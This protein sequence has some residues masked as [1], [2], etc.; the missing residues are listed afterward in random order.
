MKRIIISVF[1]SICFISMGVLYAE[2]QAQEREYQM[3]ILGGST[4][5]DYKLI[6]FPV[7]PID[8]QDPLTNEAILIDDLGPYDPFQWRFFRWD[9]TLNGGLGDYIELNQR[10]GDVVWGNDQNIDYGRGYW[11]IA[12]Q[13]ETVNVSGIEDGSNK[14]I[15]LDEG[16]NQIGNPFYSLQSNLRVGPVGGPYVPLGDDLNVYTDKFVWE[17]V[18]GDYQLTTDPLE[19]GKGYWLKN[20]TEGVVELEFVPS[21]GLSSEVTSTSYDL[22]NLDVAQEEMPPSPPAIIEGS[23][24]SLSGGSAS[25]GCFIATAAYRDYDHPNV[26][27]L[28][29][30]R[31]RYLLTNSLG[32]IFVDMYYRWSPSVAKFIVNHDSMKA[33]IRFNLM[34]I[35]GLGSL[36]IKINVYG[37]LIVLVFPML[38]GLLLLIKSGGGG[39]KCK[40]KFSIKSEGGKGKR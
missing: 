2:S 9:S 4:A 19:V 15:I 40:P 5:A 28:R 6:S 37:F 25:G 3:T 33:L 27:R 13:T 38:M 7:K 14:T 1:I 16:W 17:W 30:F 23:L 32:R 11:I 24:F 12:V 39:G 21:Q 22:S 20:I 10:E 31:D 8:D 34:P 35:A 18:G 29:E 36:V 26:Q